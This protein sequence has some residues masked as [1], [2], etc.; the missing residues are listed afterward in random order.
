MLI[1]RGNMWELPAVK[2]SYDD[3]QERIEK[4]LGD[5][6]V[7]WWKDQE[8]KGRISNLITEDISYNQEQ[9]ERF[10]KIKEVSANPE[11]L[12]EYVMTG[13]CSEPSKELEVIILKDENKSLQGQLE[14][15]Q[16]AID[17]LIMSGGVF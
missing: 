7:N 1:K 2:I 10:E 15:A 12:Y 8:T 17:F 11:Q 16:E 5:E 13:V 9:L 14:S 6:S 4:T 3:G